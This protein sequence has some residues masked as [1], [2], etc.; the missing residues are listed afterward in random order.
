VGDSKYVV[1]VGI[2]D[3]VQ[4][5]FSELLK[6]RWLIVKRTVFYKTKWGPDHPPFIC[7]LAGKNHYPK[8]T[9][10]MECTAEWDEIPYK[11]IDEIMYKVEKDSFEGLA[12]KIAK[13]VLKIM[14]DKKKAEGTAKVT[15]HVQEGPDFWVEAEENCF[16]QGEENNA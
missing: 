6:R 1:Q 16:L 14:R 8:V 12:A 15:V 9:V 7:K 13:G 4:R 10:L 2:D 5:L 3:S 11:D